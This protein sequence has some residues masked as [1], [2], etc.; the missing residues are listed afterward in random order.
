VPYQTAPAGTG[1]PGSPIPL[2]VVATLLCI[3]LGVVALIIGAKVN[4]AWDSGDH[5]GSIA[6]AKQA[7]GWAIAGIIVGGI[8]IIY[9]AGTGAFQNS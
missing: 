3:P 5:A 4:P 6:A 2:A 1:R 8:L 9:L 7:K